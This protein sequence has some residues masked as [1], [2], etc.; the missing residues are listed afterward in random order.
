MKNDSQAARCAAIYNCAW[1][2]RHYSRPAARIQRQASVLALGLVVR[3][4]FAQTDDFEQLLRALADSLA[5]A[6]PPAN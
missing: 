3:Q 4:A 5:G 6:W 1:W 2:I